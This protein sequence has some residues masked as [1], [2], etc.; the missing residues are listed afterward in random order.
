[1]EDYFIRLEINRN[2][3]IICLEVFAEL[4]FFDMFVVKPRDVALN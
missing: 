4:I 1:M 3:L 2:L